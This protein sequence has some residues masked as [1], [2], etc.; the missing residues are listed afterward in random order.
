MS[1]ATVVR[2]V[3]PPSGIVDVWHVWLDAPGFPHELLVLQLDAW[4]RRRAGRMRVGGREWSSAHGARRD[5]V[6]STP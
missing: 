6:S 1:P 4:E 2:E 5:Q 3:G